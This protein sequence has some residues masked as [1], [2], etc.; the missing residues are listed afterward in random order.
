MR[1]ELGRLDCG[2]GV[3]IAWRRVAGRGP[4]VVFLGGFKSD[5]TGSTPKLVIGS[6]EVN[7][8]DVAAVAN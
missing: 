6:M 3:E 1:E 4:G 8:S 7:L 5:M 2:D